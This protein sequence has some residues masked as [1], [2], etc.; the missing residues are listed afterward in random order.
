MT[1]PPAPTETLT[2]LDGDWRSGNVALMGARTNA[3]WL[4]ASVFDGARRFEGVMPDLDLHCERINRSAA[5][6]GLEPTVSTDTW[7]GLAKDGAKR[8]AADAALYIRPMYWA[9]AGIGGGVLFDGANP[10]WCLTLYEAPLPPPAGARVTLSPFRKP[11]ADTMPVEAKAGCLYPNNARALR[12]AA[13][14]GF[15]NCLMRDTEGRIAELANANVFM[16]KDG[17]IYTPRWTG[18]FLNGV[19]RRRIIALLKADGADV[20]ETDLTYEAFLEADEIF[21]AGNFLKVSPVV[22]IESRSLQPGPVYERAR[23]LYWDYA[24]AGG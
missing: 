1:L 24:H 15:T 18:V 4:G 13:A 14:R 7:I 10:R 3:A 20:V 5:S 11:A 9:E 17:V 12:E 2:F 6:F 21:S 19:T 23:R 8:F 16:V 22:Q